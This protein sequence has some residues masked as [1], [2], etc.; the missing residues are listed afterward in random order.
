[1]SR[2]S[3]ILVNCL[4]LI[5]ANAV[6]LTAQDDIQAL[7]RQEASL[8]NA[9]VKRM[10]AKQA[11]LTATHTE[12]DVIYYALDLTPDHVKEI[13]TGSVLMRAL[14]LVD[15]LR[16]LTLDLANPMQVNS[17]TIAGQPASYRHENNILTVTL[18]RSYLRNER[19]EITTQ[20]AGNPVATGFGSFGFSY[21]DNKPM[22]WT[23]S[24]P[25]GARDWWPCKDLPVDKADSVDIK[26]TVPANL[27]V[28]SNGL[29]RAVTDLP[30]NRKQ[31]WWHEGYPISTYL[32]S[33]A[34]HPYVTYSDWYR[35][36][37]TDSM[38]IQF[39]VFQDHYASLR[40][41]YAKTKNMIRI[42][43][44][45][46]GP[47]PFIK[48]KYGHAE[49]VWG[50]GM[51]HQTIT[52]LG[53]WSEMLI[54]HELAHMW[55]GDMITCQDFHHIWLNEGFATYS[56]ALY[57]ERAYGKADFHAYVKN[58]EYYGPG[59]IYVEN[60][61][62][63]N[64]FD[65]G[66]SYAKGGWV[67]H[68]LR[69]VVGDSNFFQIL[70]SYYADPR[71]Q[72][73]TA[74]TE[75]FQALCEQISGLDL[76]RFFQ[77]WIY[78]EG[79]PIYEYAWSYRTENDGT[80]TVSGFTRQVQK[81]G[82]I[83]RMP[84]DVTV[85]M[86]SQSRTFVHL[87]DAET[88]AF[89]FN[90]PARPT[91]LLLDG[92]NWLLNETREI[93]TAQMN[94]SGSVVSEW[95]G[96][97][98]GYLVA[99][100]TGRLVFN[101]VNSGI[102]IA[103]LQGLISCQ[104]PN[105]TITRA[106]VMFGTVQPG[107]KVLNAQEPFEFTLNQDFEPHVVKFYLKLTGANGFSAQYL[108]GVPVGK[109]RFLAIDDDGAPDLRS[110]FKAIFDSA[111]VLVRPLTP[112]SVFSAGIS[113]PDHP[114][115]LWDFDADAEDTL[116]PEDQAALTDYVA[117]GGKLVLFGQNLGRDLV[118]NGTDSDRNF[119]TNVLHAAFDSDDSRSSIVR[120]V[121][122]DP[123][124]QGLMIV[125]RTPDGINTQ[126]SPEVIL[127]GLGA[128][129]FLNYLP[130]NKSAAIR[131]EDEV[132]KIAYLGIGLNAFTGQAQKT[133]SQLLA[134]LFAWL[135]G[136]STDVVD[137]ARLPEHFELRQNYPNPF[138]TGS[139]DLLSDGGT[140]IEYALPIAAQVQV[141]IYNLLGQKVR[142][143]VRQEKPAGTFRVRWDGQDE[144][145]HELVSGVY[146]VVLKAG[147]FSASRKILKIK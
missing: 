47:Y 7:R 66:L 38:P 55:W 65:G 45:L 126:Q 147:D 39:F 80:F 84:V 88:N 103:D 101:L 131:F 18:D 71:Y 145:G 132:T 123:V 49:F 136:R 109:A 140:T 54:A 17:V 134:N 97:Q 21:H 14:V 26:V 48:E 27:I 19:V 63:D 35:Y 81:V 85:Q 116:T 44:E 82:S 133:G 143:L 23:L 12:Y 51:E 96:N 98:D 36:S 112:D 107:Q 104:D 90:V 115:V 22:I 9:G 111:Y 31:Y 78:D 37:P 41:N 95:L 128:K 46:F 129:T 1:M 122:G 92:E 102:A 58:D 20:Y 16:T 119:Y 91:G 130:V 30:D 59:T 142:T 72:Y 138:S 105:V 86:G 106:M 113:L 110:N 53:G 68:M 94:V 62:T 11:A 120:G 24:E 76:G 99:G 108:L 127:P 33:L 2:L 61:A 57:R 34:I 100:E 3:K 146:L 60:P 137:S 125:M 139:G 79:Y 29:L 4:L 8:K 135:E 70:R 117:R 77:Q 87:A 50:G 75:D 118:L 83:F 67:L 5:S 64:I 10:L 15:S 43:A 121:V 6:I 141:T 93:K 124:G 56:E 25:F 40:N 114:V 89:S 32:V 69:H 144:R 74:T 28:A 73:A 13:L 52:S 42:F